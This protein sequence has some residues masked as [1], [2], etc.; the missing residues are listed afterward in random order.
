VGRVGLMERRDEELQAG[1][2]ALLDDLGALTRAE[3]PDYDVVRLLYET[4]SRL[5]V[6]PVIHSFVAG[7]LR[8]VDL[9][10]QNPNPD[11]PE[12]NRAGLA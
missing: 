7:E 5:R 3:V 6:P 8:E 11:K 12:P 10:I 4:D 1:D 9:A 2:L